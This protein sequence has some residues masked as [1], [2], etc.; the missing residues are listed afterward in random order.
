MT[1]REFL[2]YLSQQPWVPLES[3]QEIREMADKL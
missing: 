3:Q 2:V 1:L